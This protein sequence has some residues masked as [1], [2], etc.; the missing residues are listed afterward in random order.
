MKCTLI[1]FPQSV[2]G[3]LEGPEAVPGGIEDPGIV[4]GA[5]NASVE[6]NPLSGELPGVQGAGVRQAAERLPLDVTLDLPVLQVPERGHLGGLLHPLDHLKHGDEVDV[7]VAG[8]LVDEVDELLLETLVG[9]QPTGVE[10]KSKGSP[11]RVV[12]T[13]KVVSKQSS[14]LGP[15]LDVRAG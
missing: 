10:V 5:F 13:V 15:F 1:I 2:D 12:V 11:V 6:P 9:L 4:V 3:L 14:K 7:V 8:L